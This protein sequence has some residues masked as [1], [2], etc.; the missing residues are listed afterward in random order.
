MSVIEIT[1]SQGEGTIP[2]IEVS[3]TLDAHN[4]EQLEQAFDSFFDQGIYNL[5]IEISR[6]EYISSAGAGVFIGAAGRAQANEGNI[7]VVAPRENVQEIFDLLGIC[8]IFPVVDTKKK[9]LSHFT[10]VQS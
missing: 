9:A 4:F 3:G 8:H 7:V 5:V 10:S 1:H 6:L 2:I